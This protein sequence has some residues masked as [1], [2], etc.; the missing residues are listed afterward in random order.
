MPPGP[1]S[2]SRL[3]TIGYQGRSL[4][5]LVR[6]LRDRQVV[7]LIDVREIARSRRP[8]FNATPLSAAL[9]R[10]GIRYEHAPHL[11]SPSRLRKTL[12]ETG[13]FE[14]FAGLY[15]AYVRRWRTEDV[16]DLTRAVHREGT[17]CILCYESDPELC[18][19]HIVAAEALRA[20]GGRQL[21]VEHL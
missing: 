19:R 20:R 5:N 3:L 15:L 14:R 10:A 16:A 12:Y 11:G 4:A 13:D 21:I 18:H 17:V 7:L 8:E 1:A 2:G 6:R 9:E